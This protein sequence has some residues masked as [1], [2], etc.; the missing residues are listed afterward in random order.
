MKEKIILIGGGGHCHACID[1]I[2]LQGKYEI[3]G[4]IDIKEELGAKI[5]GYP[6]IGRDEDI[7]RF[8][9]TIK[10]FHVAIGQIKSPEVRVR[11]YCAVKEAGGLLP[12]II[13]PLAYVSKHSTIGEGCII[14]HNALVNANTK[15]GVNT[16]INTKVLIEHD[17]YIGHHCHVST[18]AIINSESQ[19]GDGS[20]FGS[21]SV[22]VQ[23]VIIPEDT[24]TKA[25]SLVK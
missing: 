8:A 21:N 17:V 20:F 13:S 5:M 10:N 7:P 9:K 12:V 6:V 3:E 14:M 15:I 11:L 23:D 24:F 25:H 2:E 16:I 19:L 18:G 22:T 1:V 4:I